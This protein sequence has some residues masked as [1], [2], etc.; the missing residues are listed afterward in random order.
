M[1]TFVLLLSIWVLSVP[2]NAQDSTMLFYGFNQSKLTQTQQL[3]LDQFLATLHLEKLEKIQI[4]G[5][6]DPF[7]P[8]HYNLKLSEKRAIAV[9]RYF[10]QKGVTDA[11]LESAFYG[12]TQP[13]SQFK[14]ASQNRRVEI[15]VLYKQVVKQAKPQS[16]VQKLYQAVGVPIQEF[17]IN[18]TKDT[19]LT[20][21][22]GSMVHIKANSFQT[23][24]QTSCIRF[25][26]KEIY[27]KS[28]MILENLST[29]SN[30]QILETQ[31]MIYTNAI[32]NGDT[33][34]LKKDLAILIPTDSIH[35]NLQVFDGV[36]DEHH[37]AEINWT[38]SNNSVLRNFNVQEINDCEELSELF[39]NC[40]VT[41]SA[42]F[43]VSGMSP[44]K[45]CCGGLLNCLRTC[46]PHSF[47]F[48]R[49]KRFPTAIAGTFNKEIRKSN[50][51][52]RQCQKD[53]KSARR[54][55]ALLRAQ[56][57]RLSRQNISSFQKDL[58]RPDVLAGKAQPTEREANILEITQA[59]KQLDRKISVG[60]IGKT[61]MTRCD[62]LDSLFTAYGVQNVP[63]LVLAINKP[64]L[65][66]FGLTSMEQLLDTLPKVNQKKL[67]VAYQS[68]KISYADF[69]FYVFN[70]SSL[71]WKNCD[72]FAN[73]PIEQLT[74]LQVDEKPQLTVDCK[75]V[76]KNQR[77]VLP[78]RI[79]HEHFYFEEIPKGEKA[80]LVGIKY[81]AGKPM[82]ALKEINVQDQNFELEFEE[83]SLEALKKK[84][85][86]LDFE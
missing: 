33:L 66:E 58:I 36:R 14:T 49:I 42:R 57:G 56:N 81:E 10:K 24:N 31:G 11:Q 47:F 71:G 28:E 8:A 5:H 25:Q 46:K 38:V 6:A 51:A 52:F 76:F 77:F 30:G 2:L 1:R 72:V 45:F 82:L 62:Q 12:E 79:G 27:E 20:C 74:K 3:K 7:G 29:T 61:T 86:V 70:T 59:M 34:T 37:S 21:A 75:L 44:I 16:T 67:E 19:V 78:A 26:V 65:D 69:K 15:T 48:E 73:V 55:E 39:S 35:A 63:A 41:D 85:K 23:T 40:F 32:Q 80:W 9:M 13:N 64:L 18:P 53:L 84:L 68:K 22:K 17:C 4:I 54:I 43:F 60:A 50:Q 83:L